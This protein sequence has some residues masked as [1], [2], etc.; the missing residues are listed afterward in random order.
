MLEIGV[1]WNPGVDGSKRGT[2]VGEH[3]FSEELDGFEVGGEW[4]ERCLVVR[5]RDYFAIG[6]ENMVIGIVDEVVVGVKVEEEDRNV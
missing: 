3:D 4:K 2:V 1:C 5:K 6:S